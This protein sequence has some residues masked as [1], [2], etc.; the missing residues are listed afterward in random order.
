[1]A[2]PTTEKVR[3]VE[4]SPGLPR[5]AWW[6]GPR[7]LRDRWTRDKLCLERQLT[8]IVFNAEYVA[9]LPFDTFWMCALK[10]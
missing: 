10:S 9:D 4:C 2:D 7:R 1:M 8:T 5:E 3:L 6:S